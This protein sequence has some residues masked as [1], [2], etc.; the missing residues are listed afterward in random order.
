M[1]PIQTQ[2]KELEDMLTTEGI[3]QDMIDETTITINNLKSIYGDDLENVAVF[4]GTKITTKFINKSD[5]KDP[6]YQHEGDSG[7]DFRANIETPLTIKPLERVLVPTGL[8]FGF[9]FCLFVL[10]HLKDPGYS[11]LNM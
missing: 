11:L 7:F 8:N 5:N 1:N 3:G 9:W 2:V 4:E 10:G 6:V